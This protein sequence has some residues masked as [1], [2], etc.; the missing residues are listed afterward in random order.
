MLGCLFYHSF[1]PLPILGLHKFLILFK[2]ATFDLIMF[3]LKVLLTVTY[4]VVELRSLNSI[5]CCI[6]CLLDDTAVIY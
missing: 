3:I 1:C 5:Y 6:H 2:I 4:C